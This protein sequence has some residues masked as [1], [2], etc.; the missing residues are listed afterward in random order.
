MSCLKRFLSSHREILRQQHYWDGDTK[1]TF[2]KKNANGF[3]ISIEEYDNGFLLYTDTGFHDHIEIE[4]ARTQDETLIDLFG[5]VRDMLS[6]HMRIR[7]IMK[8]DK[9]VRWYL[10]Y[11]HNETWHLESGVT[12]LLFNY[13]GKRSERI[14]SNDTLPPRPFDNV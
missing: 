3:D 4:D 12:L 2:P 8:N 9:P 7:V 1:I 6:K 10:E 11:Y 5:L 13:F 14:Y